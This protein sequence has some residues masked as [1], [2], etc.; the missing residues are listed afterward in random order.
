MEPRSHELHVLWIR[1][2][3]EHTHHELLEAFIEFLLFLETSPYNSGAAKVAPNVCDDERRRAVVR[4]EL[5]H[6][7]VKGH[8]RLLATLKTTVF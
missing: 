3:K 6:L 4:L 8:G 5:R 1:P 2:K 7:L